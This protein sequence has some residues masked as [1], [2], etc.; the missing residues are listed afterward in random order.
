MDVPSR[1]TVIGSFLSPYVRKVLAVLE[2]K[3][4]AWEID[5]V[6]PFYADDA[7]TGLSP[8]RRIPVLIDGETTLADSTVI[9]E[10]LEERYPAAPILPDDVCQRAEARWLEEYADSVMGEVFIWRYWY[11]VIINRFI[12]GNPP[13]QDVVSQAVEEDLPEIFD[14]L[15]NRLPESGTLF[16]RVSVADIAI[17]SFFRNLFLARFELDGERWPNTHRFVDHLLE[18]PFFKSLAAY[19][20]LCMACR[21][22]EQRSRL[23]EAGAPISDITFG[24]ATPRKAILSR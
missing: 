17:A 4:I 16:D 8:A 18:M 7:F 24:T 9:V 5:P 6:V 1:V 12:W 3:R 19:E 23:L 15:E 14:Y 11:Q 13:D 10:Y 22:P 20:D 2:L 21:V